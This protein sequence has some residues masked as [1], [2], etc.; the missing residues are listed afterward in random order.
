MHG[1][2]GKVITRGDEDQNSNIAVCRILEIFCKIVY[3]SL[4]KCCEQVCY[5]LFSHSNWFM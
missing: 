5:N 3:N 2:G 1:D 4:S